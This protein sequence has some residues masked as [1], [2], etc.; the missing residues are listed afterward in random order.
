LGLELFHDIEDRWNRGA[1]GPE[2]EACQSLVDRQNYDRGL[3]LGREKIFEVRRIYN[4]IGFIDEF[5]TEEFARKHRL[6]N[7]DYNWQT[8]QYEI[9]SREF[10]EIKQRLLLQ[11][12]NFGQPIIEVVDA[13]HKNR[14]ELLLTHCHEGIDLDIPFA[15]DTLRNLFVLWKRPVHIET[16][17]DG[18]RVVYSQNDA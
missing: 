7:F 5:V 11:L 17:V 16:A 13:N 8:E 1:F 10:L 6:F 3:G 12:T 4:D 2:Y 15:K 14:G 18:K 9:A